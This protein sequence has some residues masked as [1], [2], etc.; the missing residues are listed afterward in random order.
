MRATTFEFR[1]RVL[2]IAIIFAAGFSCSA[3]DRANA[4]V[5]VA[6]ATSSGH[7]SFDS[8]TGRTRVRIVFAAGALVIAAG[9]ILRTWGASYLRSDVVHDPSLRTE[10]LVADGPYRFV[11]N[12]LYLGTLLMTIGFGLLASRIGWIVLVAGIL[13]FEY[14]LMF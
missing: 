13:L 5:A 6:R 3:F 11:R 4:A 14:R 10:G 12:P 7:F 2:V 9:A 1:Y 8:A